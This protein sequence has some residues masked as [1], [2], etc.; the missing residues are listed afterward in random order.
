MRTAP[1]GGDGTGCMPDRTEYRFHHAGSVQRRTDPRSARTEAACC[2]GR[3][4]E[5]QVRLGYPAPPFG[6]PVRKGTRRA[7]V[8]HAAGAGQLI[9]IGGDPLQDRGHPGQVYHHMRPVGMIAFGPQVDHRGKLAG[10]HVGHPVGALAQ[11]A[12]L[13]ERAVADQV[14][15]VQL[16]IVIPAR[17]FRCGP[18]RGPQVS[19]RGIQRIQVC[20][21]RDLVHPRRREP[22]RGRQRADRDPL[23]AGRGQRPRPFPLGRRWRCSGK[24]AITCPSSALPAAPARVSCGTRSR[25]ARDGIRW[26]A[27]RRTPPTSTPSRPV[28]RRRRARPSPPRKKTE[29]PWPR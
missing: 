26:S 24:R 14:A 18:A 12:R 20:A 3:T 23:R 15:P 4:P 11:P 13:I 28:A 21:G 29:A 8:G 10:M 25:G 9:D 27:R 17:V 16:G 5:V 1:A 2:G 6:P 22:R 7:E 19:Q